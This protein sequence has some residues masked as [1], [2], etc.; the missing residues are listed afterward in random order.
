MNAAS[1]SSLPSVLNIAPPVGS[2]SRVFVKLRSA[3]YRPELD[4]LRFL[5]FLAVFAYHTL[6][7]RTGPAPGSHVPE[8]FAATQAALARGGAFGVDL[9]FVLSAYLITELLLREKEQQGSLDIGAF[10]V[11]RILR[12]WPIYYLFVILCGLIPA[13][14]PGG[15]PS[16]YFIPYLLLV[17]NWSAVAFGPPFTAALPL[18]SVSVEEQFYLLW[19]PLVA[20]CSRRR[21]AL[22]AVLMIGVANLSR[23]GVLLLH[24]VHWTDAPSWTDWAGWTVWANTLARLDPIAAGIL[25]ALWLRGT[26]PAL[27]ATLRLLLIGSGALCL[28]TVGHFAISWGEGLPWAGTLIAYPLVA[29]AA[30]CILLGFLGMPVRVPALQY[31]GKISY[32]LYVYHFMCIWIA[33]RLL[34]GMSGVMHS[35][36]REILA[37]ALTIGVAAASYVLIEQRFLRLK[38]RFTH[39]ES[40]PV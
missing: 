24:A 38:S 25:L 10:Y 13:L 14:S 30:S 20:R 27:P 2:S 39:V 40:R 32:G 19:P 15:F 12:I 18:W 8:W 29:T 6:Y 11:R 3:F 7:F 28:A 16:H 1:G 9:F 33:D 26:V 17:G 34:H 37:L 21:L 35:V 22:I 36:L 23:V 31:L 5:A 4:I